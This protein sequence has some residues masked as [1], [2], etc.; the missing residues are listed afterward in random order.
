[1]VYLIVLFTINHTNKKI[2]Y[3]SGGIHTSSIKK[4]QTHTVK[5]SMLDLIYRQFCSI[6]CIPSG[7]CNCFFYINIYRILSVLLLTTIIGGRMVKAPSLL[8][9]LHNV[10]FF[11][12]NTS[13]LL[14]HRV[15]ASSTL[16][17]HVTK[18][19]D[20]SIDLRVTRSTKLF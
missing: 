12:C 3:C 2:H 18:R 14:G 4:T 15:S 8:G 10:S 16:T 20:G 1:M 5:P 11:Y 7:H 6:H 9:R 13:F 19:G 17:T